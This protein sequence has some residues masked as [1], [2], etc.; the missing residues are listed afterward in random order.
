M[1]AETEIQRLVVRLTGDSKQYQKSLKEATVST[2]KF[3]RGID[4]KLRDAQGKFVN[5]QRAMQARLAATNSLFKKGVIIVGS[6]AKTLGTKVVGSLK[7]LVARLVLVSSIALPALGIAA[8]KVGS[9]FETAFVGV[10]KTVDATTEQLAQL[11]RGFQDLSTEIPVAATELLGIGE[12]AGQLGIKTENILSFTETIAQLSVTTN[13]STEEAASSLAKFAN[14]T[15]LS[16]TKFSNL[17]SSIVALGNSMAT[18]ERDIVS[19]ATRLAG[20]GSTIGLTESE[21]LALAASLSSVGLESEAGG[22]AFSKLFLEMQTAVATS[23]KE[24]EAFARV[25]GKTTEEFSGQFR[26]NAV[27]AIRDLLK[28]LEQ[29]APE[30]RVLALQKIGVEGTRMTDAML[31]ASGA[32]DLLDTALKTSDKAFE[33][34]VA[35]SKEAETAFKAFGAQVVILKNEVK[36][37]MGDAFVA[38]RPILIEIINRV[39]NLADQFRA[40]WLPVLQ[41]SFEV[42]KERLA[43]SLRLAA[44]AFDELFV[45]VE[46]LLPLFSEAIVQS[47]ATLVET[48]LSLLIPTLKMAAK[49]FQVLVDVAKLFGVMPPEPSRSSRASGQATGRGF[50]GVTLEDI[51]PPT[52]FIGLSEDTGGGANIIGGNVSRGGGEKEA[53]SLLEQ[54][55]QQSLA[56]AIGAD[57][58]ELERLSIAGASEETLR[59][60]KSEQLWLRIIQKQTEERKKQTEEVKKLREGAER[61]TAKAQQD[62][63]VRNK[64][65]EAQ[66]DAIRDQFLTP[67]E[68]FIKTVRGLE[69]LEDVGAIDKETLT[70]AVAGAEKD[71][72]SEIARQEEARVQPREATAFR[73]LEAISRTRDF[74]D[75]DEGESIPK[76]LAEIRDTGL[77]QLDESEQLNQNLQLAD[78]A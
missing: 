41:K 64:A 73:G 71:F 53:K 55:Q 4:G 40:N 12:A 13:L 74:L 31:R 25:S 19:M 69:D 15:G 42:V 65:I 30:D 70:R 32:V 60:V 66:G 48:L 23:G 37:L 59:A 58:A 77:Q 6:Y 76:L 68:K 45:T 17:G 9:D 33:E 34:N 52:T 21:I 62:F 46:P 8:I 38:V 7:R 10:E 47:I 57:A 67:Q 14:I 2:E 1:A 49:Q 72:R 29:L 50:G 51:V 35:L 54:L 16:Q 75:Q 28:S 63:I 27:G 44:D 5:D 3:T 39:K 26:T 24:L 78:T 22:T 36:R 18:T 11:R 20:A 56:F 43:P 61:T